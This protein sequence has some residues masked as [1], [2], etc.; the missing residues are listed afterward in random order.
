MRNF[1][2]LIALVLVIACLFSF[3]LTASAADYTDSPNDATTMWVNSTAKKEMVYAKPM[4]ETNP[5]IEASDMKYADGTGIEPFE[6]L[7]DIFAIDGKIYVLDGGSSRI[8]V[9]D[10]NYT[11]LSEIKGVIT[12]DGSTTEF[13]GA[14]GI[15]V[16]ENG[17][18]YISDHDHTRV[19]ITDSKGK[20]ITTLTKP[21]DDMWPNDL[22]FNPIKVIKDKMGYLYVLCN[23]SFYGAAM[24]TPAPEYKFKGFFGANVTTTNIL[25]AVNKL[26]D[27]LFTNSVKRSKSAKALPYS[28]VDMEL[29]SDGYI[30]TCTGIKGYDR[31]ATGS[32]R[33]LNPTGTNIL[34]DKSTGTAVDSTN[35]VFGAEDFAKRHGNLIKHDMT[36]V[37]IDN[38]NYIYVLDS[39]YGR[40]YVYDLEC[41]MLNTLGGGIDNGTQAGTFKKAIAITNMNGN[42][43]AIDEIKAGIVSFTI[44]SYGELVQQAQALTM[45]GDY[46]DAAPLWREVL[47]V[48]RNSMIAY[49]GLAKAYLIEGKYEKAMEYAERGYDRATYSAAYGYVRTEFTEKH[50]TI[51]FIGVIL[52]VV[53][54]VLGLN[55][56]KKKNIVLIKNKKVKV[57]LGILTHPADTFYEI[58]R[59]GNGSIIVATVIL[60]LW[61]IF[62]IIGLTSGFIF[63]D[64]S[65]IDVNAWYALAQTFGLV[66]LFV[67]SNWLVCV[68][69]EGKAKLKEIYIVTCYSLIPMVIQ[70]IGYDIL[71]NVLTLNEQSFLNILNYACIILTAAY[72][73]MGIIN[74]QEFTLGKFIFTTVV[75]LLAM[76]LIIFLIFL[77]GIL[78]QQSGDFI[79]T[80]VME[81]LYR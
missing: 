10:E 42:I 68:L 63:N 79:K 16:D 8:I 71:S 57:A 61:Y 24:Y 65:I 53:A 1:K 81:V 80:V 58:K 28:F 54:L 76:I 60:V 5:L 40:I 15:M 9:L 72:L 12:A 51:I 64:T 66:A 78:V 46:L 35:M 41:N 23:G 29:G 34:I 48:D 20:L 32:V 33:R 70:A 13:K 74:I 2:R 44:N 39:A 55:Y 30:Y 69:F 47:K 50:F 3:A 7:A 17:L 43:Y 75:T 73:I 67:L 14:R 22:N 11:V 49:R 27:I 18:I 45:A 25:E 36:S 19:L 4:Y 59:N 31:K 6:K 62:K 56:K 38:N 77:V 37:T 26:W 21:I 52:L